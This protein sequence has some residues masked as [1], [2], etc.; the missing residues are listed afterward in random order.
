MLDWYEN[1]YGV[2]NGGWQD[3]VI[4]NARYAVIIVGGRL[5]RWKDGKTMYDKLVYNY[6][7]LRVNVCLMLSKWY[8]KYNHFADVIHP[9]GCQ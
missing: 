4:Y 6:N 2:Q 3:P 9:F 1:K 5:E 7:Y 8:S